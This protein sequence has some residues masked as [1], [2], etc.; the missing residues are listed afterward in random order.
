MSDDAAVPEEGGQTAVPEKRFWQSKKWW[1]GIVGVLVPVANSLFGW[2][3]QVEEILPILTPLFA[4]II[5]Q[6]LA[7]FGKNTAGKASAPEKPI[8]K[9]KKFVTAVLGAAVPAISAIIAKQTGTQVDS[10]LIYGIVGVA[11]AYITGQGLS[12]FG[13]NSGIKLKS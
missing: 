6:G 5:G 1:I 2:H 4:Y 7:D 10:Q 9:S 8:W 12:D 11:A 13:K 3:L